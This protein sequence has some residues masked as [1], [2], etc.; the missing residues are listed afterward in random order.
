MSRI[1][2]KITFRDHRKKKDGSFALYMRITIQRK[3][4]YLPLH[5]DVKKKDFDPSRE[6]IKKSDPDHY[7]KN[8]IIANAQS[9]AMNIEKHFLF[10]DQSPTLTE[11]V[12]QYEASEKNMDCFYSFA[13]SM[14]RRRDIKLSDAT[15]SFYDKH[16]G[17]LKKFRPE[18]ALG[19]IDLDFLYAYRDHC[20]ALG[21]N[22]NTMYKSLE[23][24]RRVINA[25]INEDKNIKNPFRSF[26]IR[27]LRGNTAHL[28][29]EELQQ[30]EKLYNEGSLAKAEH[31]VLR[32]FLFACYTGLRYADVKNLRF[33]NLVTIDGH[34]WLSF[35][36]QKTDKHTEIF[37]MP[38]ALDLIPEKEFDNAPVFR[39]VPNQT[40]NRHLKEIAKRLEWEK[41]L[42]FHVARHTC[43]NLLYRLGVP[44]EIRAKI[45]GDTTH[46]LQTHY[47]QTDSGMIRKA[48]GDFSRALG[49]RRVVGV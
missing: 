40:T 27:T 20:Y 49:E 14:K 35:A 45:V 24:V 21:N 18:L 48:I 19:E 6:Q 1:S 34:T 43:S 13:E 3:I 33:S 23:F 46:V 2:A 4:K 38:Q 10:L 41:R 29:I 36:Q 7:H 42:T 15:I 39:V 44:A 9:K 28:N 17:K 11:F 8:M 25:A 32:Y 47:T 31:N 12:K 26:K 5:I 22:D 30:L 37:L 16:I